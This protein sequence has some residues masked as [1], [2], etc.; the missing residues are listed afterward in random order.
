MKNDS[1]YVI[2]DSAYQAQHY[3]DK[4]LINR[5]R[6]VYVWEPDRLRGIRGIQVILYGPLEKQS[7]HIHEYYE[8]FERGGLDH[9]RVKNI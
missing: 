4:M 6:L 5:R 7:K 9:I 3:I 1:V 8:I 2:A